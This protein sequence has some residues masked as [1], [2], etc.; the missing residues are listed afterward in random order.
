MGMA[1]VR[2]SGP[3]GGYSDEDLL[4]PAVAASIAMRSV[5]TIRRAY[6]NGT[7]RAYR[8]ANGR[9][10]RIRYGD[11]C[12]WMKFEPV[13]VRAVQSV[14]SP[15]P[16]EAGVVAAGG[17]NPSLGENLALLDAARE[18]RRRH[19]RPGASVRVAAVQPGHFRA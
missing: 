14:Q 1:G 4:T 9:G 12:T 13:A 5:R 8:D 6:S 17:R 10:V 15:R 3:S 2:A 18:A 16:G 19:K 7:L 11:L